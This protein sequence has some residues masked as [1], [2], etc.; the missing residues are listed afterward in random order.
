MG[1]ELGL[2]MNKNTTFWLHHTIEIA[3]M[4]VTWK[5]MSLFFRINKQCMQISQNQCYN[6]SCHQTSCN[7][8]FHPACTDCLPILE[9]R[10]IFSFEMRIELI[11]MLWGNLKIIFLFICYHQFYIWFCSVFWMSTKFKCR[12]SQWWRA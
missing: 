5:N 2:Y 12:I 3:L 4:A 7:F 10:V 1:N 8:C 9:K 6:C 11:S